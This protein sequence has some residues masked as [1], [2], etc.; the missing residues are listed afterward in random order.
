[1]RFFLLLTIVVFIG[2]NSAEKQQIKQHYI[3]STNAIE[4]EKFKQHIIDSTREAT[5]MENLHLQ[6]EQELDKE[7]RDDL[8]KAK[9]QLSTLEAEMIVQ[10]DRLQDIKSL[11]LLRSQ[12]TR[13]DQIRQ[14]VQVMQNLQERI[15]QLK[16][17]IN[18]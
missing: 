18:H 3:D 10:E 9:K 2:C 11:K 14:Q 5:T 12:Q 13:E 1:M 7:R 8:L 15:E 6:E 4:A 16:S 17:I